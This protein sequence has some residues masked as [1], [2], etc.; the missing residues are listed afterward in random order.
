MQYNEDKSAIFPIDGMCAN[1]ER[2]CPTYYIAY[3]QR[4]SDFI[5][6]APNRLDPASSTNT[7]GHGGHLSLLSGRLSL[8]NMDTSVGPGAGVGHDEA[9][10]S[11]KQH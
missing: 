8:N 3:K 11:C 6:L 4:S 9:K 5:V 10:R 7:C 1:L 2:T